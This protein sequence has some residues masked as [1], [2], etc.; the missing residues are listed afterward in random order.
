MDRPDGVRCARHTVLQAQHVDRERYLPGRVVQRARPSR[1]P[2][3][4]LY[5]FLESFWRS[6]LAR[7]QDQHCYRYYDELELGATLV[8][9]F[10]SQLSLARVQAF[11]DMAGVSW[12]RPPK[13]SDCHHEWCDYKWRSDLTY[14]K[15]PFEERLRQRADAVLYARMRA[16]IDALY[17][18]PCAPES[19]FGRHHWPYPRPLPW[20]RGT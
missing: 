10:V 7:P 11:L 5:A 12:R 4:Q 15:L 2:C 3:A 6:V 20:D 19:P 18:E 1:P 16:E 17:L 8:S 9:E 14:W 13:A